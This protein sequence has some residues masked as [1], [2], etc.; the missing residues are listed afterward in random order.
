MIPV[1]YLRLAEFI[2]ALALVAA[3]CWGV[4][5][6][7][8]HERDIGYQRAVAE[9]T[10][11]EAAAK[12]AARLREQDLQRQLQEARNA[13]T[14]RDQTIRDTA[15]AAAAASTSLHDALGALR[16]RVPGA[17]ADALGKSVTT[18]TTVLDDCQAKY[19]GMAEVA[20]RHASDVKTLTDAWP[21]PPKGAR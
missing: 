8:E 5:E 13:A 4:H 21:T 10:A 1:A 18:L 3:V 7:L 14:L 6:F 2:G 11:K 15:T 9:Y 20:D 12:D 16:S 19:R 17:T